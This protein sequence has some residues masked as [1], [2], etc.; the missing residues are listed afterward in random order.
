MSQALVDIEELVVQGLLR[1][2]PDVVE[3]VD[4]R[5]Y[6]K[7]P[8][9]P[10]FPLVRV[11]RL[12]GALVVSHHAWLDAP[13][14]QYDVWGDTKKATWRIADTVR[15]ALIDG[16]GQ[17]YSP[18]GWIDGVTETIA[19]HEVDDPGSDRVHFVG[20]MRLISRPLPEV[21]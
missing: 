21:S 17:A 9:D 20:E 3:A 14:I 7:V 1:T 2:H 16:Q 15:R 18:M 6:T 19:P 4:T 11:R 5:V 12:G 10:T 8:S 13:R